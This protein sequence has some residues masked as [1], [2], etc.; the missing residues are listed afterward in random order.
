MLSPA[1]DQRH[2]LDAS[3]FCKHGPFSLWSVLSTIKL[4]SESVCDLYRR[5]SYTFSSTNVL[6]LFLKHFYSSSV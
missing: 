3:E 5:D 6:F 1:W 4:D 2:F